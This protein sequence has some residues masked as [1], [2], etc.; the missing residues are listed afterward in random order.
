MELTPNDID[1]LRRAVTWCRDVYQKRQRVPSEGTPEWIKLATRLAATA[2]YHALEFKPW[3]IPPVDTHD[4]GVIDPQLGLQAGRD[5]AAPENARARD[6][7]LR[8][9]CACRDH[10]S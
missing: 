9:R 3:E 4:N 8:A 7:Y 6:L 2:Q 5:R 1:A 10:K